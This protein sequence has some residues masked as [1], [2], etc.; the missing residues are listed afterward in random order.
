MRQPLEE[1]SE[2][3]VAGDVGADRLVEAAERA[4]RR[5]IVRVPEEAHVEDDVRVA[6]QSMAVGEGAD[7]DADGGRRIELEMTM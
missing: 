2:V 7:K 5:D 3:G 6:R 1:E 4:Q